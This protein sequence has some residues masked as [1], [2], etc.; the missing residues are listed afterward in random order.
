MSTKRFITFSVFLCLACVVNAQKTESIEWIAKREATRM[1]LDSMIKNMN[2]L[3]ADLDKIQALVDEKCR[4][5]KD[6]PELMSKIAMD[7][8]TLGGQDGVADERFAKLKKKYPKYI[9]GYVDHANLLQDNGLL[10]DAITKN[11]LY[12][13]RAKAQ[14]DSAKMADPRS[15]RPYSAWIQW[16]APLIK[17]DGVEEEIMAEVEAWNKQ[18]PDSGAY[19]RAAALVME[20]RPL[21]SNVYNY[22]DRYDDELKMRLAEKLLE[23]AGSENTSLAMLT[24]LAKNYFYA[25]YFQRGA[26]V[27]ELGLQTGKNDTVFHSW[28]L[29][30][31]AMAARRSIR[32]DKDSITGWQHLNKALASVDWLKAHPEKMEFLDYVYTGIAC[33]EGGKYQEA[34]DAHEKALANYK[35]S[36]GKGFQTDK[37]EIYNNLFECVNHEADLMARIEKQKE[38]L[39]QVEL[40]DTSFQ[41][42]HL[43]DI[44]KTY[45]SIGRNGDV[46][47]DAE[48][49]SAYA[50]ADSIWASLQNAVD[51]GR[52]N[53]PDKYSRHS[54]LFSQINTRR[55]MDRID[56]ERSFMT[57]IELYEKVVNRLE[58]QAELRDDER[59]SLISSASNLAAYYSKLNNPVVGYYAKIWLELDPNIPEDIVKTLKKA[60]RKY[61]SAHP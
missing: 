4:E 23:K 22:K 8:S 49:L 60:V 27:A 53:L 26:N 51:A 47:T 25:G 7:F 14:L 16:R 24:E 1:V 29:W 9:G 38:L 18:F 2:K 57:S 21:V 43:Q 15:M 54:F 44:A 17:M 46:Y 35:A 50:S 6:D 34:I 42:S 20:A 48:R 19:A 30:N 28:S 12:M 56:K 3:G 10:K 37:I 61:G 45:E 52:I 39:R 11:D 31:N 13:K 58:N 59:K 55:N 32:G 41:S 33:Q 36:I 5:M 40:I